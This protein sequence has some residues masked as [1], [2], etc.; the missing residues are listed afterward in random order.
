MS[1]SQ[2]SPGSASSCAATV[3]WRPRWSPVRTAV[4]AWTCEPSSA[5]TSVDLPTP[6]VPRNASVRP[7][8]ANAAQ[9]VDAV[10]AMPAVEQHRRAEGDVLQLAA[11]RLGILGEVG[12][13]EHDD[14]LGTA[15][16]G[17]HELALEPPLVRPAQPIECVMNTTSMLA[18]SVSDSARAPSNEARRTNAERRSRTCSTRSPSAD[19]TTQSPTATSAPMFRTRRTLAGS[20]ASRPDSTVLQPRSRRAMRPGE[21]G[22]PRSRHVSS[23]HPSH[24]SAASPDDSP[25]DE[26]TRA[27]PRDPTTGPSRRRCVPRSTPARPFVGGRCGAGCSP[28]RR[29]RAPARGRARAARSPSRG[30]R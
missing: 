5:L 2:P 10:E 3:V 16:V 4:V 23:N 18:A 30:R 27:R 8:A 7:P 21:P 9:L 28:C 6:L 26:V 13:R 17:Q 19:G 25:G 15:V 24:P 22:A 11:G 20:A 14:G 12:L 29:R 1:T